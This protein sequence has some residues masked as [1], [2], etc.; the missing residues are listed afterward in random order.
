MQLQVKCTEN[1]KREKKKIERK[2]FSHN[3]MYIEYMRKIKL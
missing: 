3:F 2:F 1:R